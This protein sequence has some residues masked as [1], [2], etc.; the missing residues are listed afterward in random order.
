M[1]PLQNIKKMGFLLLRNSRNRHIDAGKTDYKK[2]VKAIKPSAV[3][4]IEA[5]ILKRHP[6]E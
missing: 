1:V 2:M 3:K 6:R 5:N 4:C